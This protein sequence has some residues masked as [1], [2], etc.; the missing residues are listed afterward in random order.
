MGGCRTFTAEEYGKIPELGHIE[1]FENLAL[2]A[3]TVP[4]EADGR[5][6][7]VLVMIRE[8]NART[9]GY[10]SADYT[11]AT[12]ES[13]GEHVHGSAFSVGNTFSSAKQLAD[14]RFDRSTTHESKS[15]TSV[16]GD[17]VV[18]FGYSM[19][20]ACRNRFLAGGKMA[21]TSDLFFLV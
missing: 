15:V 13:F 14:D 9:N 21:E 10:L 2:V 5:V 6:F 3:G 8:C 19:L 16:S 12:V 11:I 20:N 4:V 18:F 17:Y 7:V 1:C